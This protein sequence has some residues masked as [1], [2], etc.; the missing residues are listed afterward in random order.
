M[1]II[2]LSFVVFFWKLHSVKKLKE[3][4]NKYKKSLN[5]KI[6]FIKSLLFLILQKDDNFYENELLVILLN[7]NILNL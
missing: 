5:Y 2:S 7:E 1:A 3:F 4:F 6:N